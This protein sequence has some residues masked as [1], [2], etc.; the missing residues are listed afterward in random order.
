MTDFLCTVVRCYVAERF[1][2]TYS[3]RS[4]CNTIISPADLTRFVLGI[5]DYFEAIA[6]L[7]HKSNGT[8]IT[9]AYART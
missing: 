9:P 4:P 6:Y 8:K 3:I 2:D 1:V 5:G 7:E